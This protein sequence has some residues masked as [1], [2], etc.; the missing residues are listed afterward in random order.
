M[1]A[2]LKADWV[3]ALR[4]GDFE[5]ARGELANESHSALCC[6]GVGYKVCIGGNLDKLGSA[7]LDRTFDAACRL[8]L[9]IEQQE[10]LIRMNDSD[11]KSFPQI[12]DWIEA[13]L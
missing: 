5:Q 9:L 1:D 3:K 7:S 12:A 8:G 10:A 11:R 4:S 13:N 6:I 2:K